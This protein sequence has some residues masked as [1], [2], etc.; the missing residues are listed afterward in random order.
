MKPG[1]VTGLVLYVLTST[2]AASDAPVIAVAS[3]FAPVMEEITAQ[4]TAAT[5]HTIRMSTGA[6]VTLV[7]QIERGAPFEL[8]LSADEE[9]VFYLRERGL[10]RDEGRLYAVGLLAMYLPNTSRLRPAADVAQVV[11]QVFQ[12]Q[13]LRVAIANPEL[14]P[15][16]RAA[17][18][19]LARFGNWRMLGGRVILGENVGQAAQF[20]LTGAVDA[21]FLPRALTRDA[22]LV[23]A[24]KIQIVPADWYVPLRHRMIVLKHGGRTATELY[25]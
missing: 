25:E 5:G 9:H 3:S 23:K 17:D 24:G 13:D 15:Y 1:I 22:S 12:R 21:A 10:A 18:Q 8:F 2:P 7:S 16:G 4:F 6:T 11:Q 19:V 20:A 14:A